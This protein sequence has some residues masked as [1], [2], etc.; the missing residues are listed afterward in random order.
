MK[1][2]EQYTKI[3]ESITHI[4]GNSLANPDLKLLAS[5]H[6][7]IIDF[8]IWLEILKDRPEKSI[9]ENAIKEYQI[10]I[11]SNCLGLYQQAFMGL[12]FFL[13]RSLVAIQFSANEIELNL[14][15]IGERDTYW[16]ELMDDDKGV[17]SSK[18]CRA[19]FPELKGEITHFKAITKKVYRECSEYVHGNNSVINKIPNSLEYSKKLFEEW[20]SKA[21]IINRIILFT[22]CLRYLKIL[23]EE[24]LK[25]VSDSLIEEFNSISPINQIITQ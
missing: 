3:G 13:E 24:E 22:L 9:F 6:S 12:R 25:K 10:S 11:L 19:F 5:N 2:E 16:S 15:K 14:W 4:L 7:F 17:F 20:N 18:F 8:D 23:K 1:I 21:D